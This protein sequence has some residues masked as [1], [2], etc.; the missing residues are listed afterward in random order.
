MI[1][2]II[3]MTIRSITIT[4]LPDFGSGR[5]VTILR[6]HGSR[7]LPGFPAA[8]QH[9]YVFRWGCCFRRGFF[10]QLQT[11]PETC[12]VWQLLATTRSL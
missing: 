1:F 6:V 12:G 10:L 11:H 9:R 3:S 5:D 4:V 8:G 7:G 2:T